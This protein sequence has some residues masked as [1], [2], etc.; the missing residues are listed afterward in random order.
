M[1]RLRASLLDAIRDFFRQRTYLEVET[2]LLSHDIVVDA[3]LEPFEV[4]SPDDRLFLQTSPEAGMKRLLAAGSGSIFQV[5]R[6]FRRHEFGSKH[7]PEFT[8]IEW[9][10]VGTT[11]RDQVQ[12]TEE[13]VRCVHSNLNADA[14][15]ENAASLTAVVLLD[16]PF[17]CIAYADAFARSIVSS[18]PDRSVLDLT[19]EQLRLMAAE[20]SSVDSQTCST[21]SRD[22]LLNILLAECVEP[23]L[24]SGHP[25]FLHDY[26]ASQAALAQLNPTDSHTACRFE[27]YLNGLELCNGYQE[28]TNANEL[29][30]RDEQQNT[31]RCE[32]AVQTLPGAGRMLAAMNAGLPN[33][34]GVA[35]GF[36]RLIMSLLGEAKIRNVIPFPIDRA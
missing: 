16:T 28:L 20:Y 15:T 7:N 35:L 34:S 25:E 21:F 36:D 22:D 32:H 29:Q 31:S 1:L 33:C 9:Y 8:M 2:P 23:F 10:G 11:W 26:P 4:Q 27:L 30:R 6:A 18:V 17:D 5:T 3:H 12:L 19:T 24:G 13:L 14:A